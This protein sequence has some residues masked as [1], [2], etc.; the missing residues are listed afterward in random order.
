MS[1]NA[2]EFFSTTT[3]LM[4]NAQREKYGRYCQLHLG[5][6]NLLLFQA[7]RQFP[8]S[9][10]PLLPQADNSCAAFRFHKDHRPGPCRIRGAQVPEII[11]LPMAGHTNRWPFFIPLKDFPQKMNWCYL[12]RVRSHRL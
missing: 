5:Q 3:A 7:G 4:V 11:F 2:G 10:Y 12:A 1:K 6:H 8:E 9:A